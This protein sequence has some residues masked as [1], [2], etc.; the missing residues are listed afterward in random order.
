[1]DKEDVEN[2]VDEKGTLVEKPK[3]KI[4]TGDHIIKIKY[5]DSL[6]MAQKYCKGKFPNVNV[7][8]RDE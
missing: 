3:I 5:F 4:F 2:Y 1:M 6:D 7:I 8:F